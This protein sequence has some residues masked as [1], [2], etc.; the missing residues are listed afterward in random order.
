MQ[1]LQQI[2]DD[3]VV[4]AQTLLEVVQTLQRFIADD[5]VV[6]GAHGLG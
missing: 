3:E 2:S 6:I 4:G 1:F 5:E